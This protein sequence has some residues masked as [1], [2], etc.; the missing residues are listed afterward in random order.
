MNSAEIFTQA[1]GLL[2]ATC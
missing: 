1:L 2:E